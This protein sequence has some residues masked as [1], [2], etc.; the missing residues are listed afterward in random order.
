MEETMSRTG[1][2]R[3]NRL[4]LLIAASSFLLSTVSVFAIDGSGPRPAGSQI[5][6]LDFKDLAKIEV[7]SVGKKQEKFMQSAAAVSVINHDDIRRSGATSIGDILRLIPGVEVA[8][9]NSNT[10]AI[11]ARGFN[12]TTA[13]KLLVLVDGRSVYSSLY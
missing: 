1:F 8:R 3:S 13:N 6:G 7:T 5:I 4:L 9:V 12:S 10:W 2:L 11:S